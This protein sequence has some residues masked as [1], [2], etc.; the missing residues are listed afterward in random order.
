ML[1]NIE[2]FFEQCGWQVSSL[3]QKSESERQD[4]KPP[5]EECQEESL[6][7]PTNGGRGGRS[8]IEACL[9]L[10][11]AQVA[12]RGVTPPSIVPALDVLK[13]RLLGLFSGRVVMSVNPLGLQR[14]PE[15]FHCGVIVAVANP[16]H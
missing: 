16:A 5:R 10:F 1:P 15:A 3:T 12:Y 6:T 4:A 9:E 11:G 13:D 8:S 7:F 2:D 14:P